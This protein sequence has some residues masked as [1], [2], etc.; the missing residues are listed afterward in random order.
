MKFFARLRQNRSDGPV[1]QKSDIPASTGRAAR[2]KYAPVGPEH[3]VT[4][5]RRYDRLAAEGYQQNVIAYRAINLVARGVSSIP[6]RVKKGQDTLAEHPL[7]SLLQAP[8]PQQKGPGF[9]YNLVGFHLIAGNAFILSVGRDGAPPQELWLLRP[10]TVSVL[11]GRDC[12]P[13]GYIQQSMGAKRRFTAESILHWKAFNPLNDWYGMAPLEAAA[14]A[15]DAHNEGSRWNLAL[16]QNGGTPSG[17]LYQEDSDAHLTDSQFR[18]LK[19]QVEDHYTGAVNAGRPLLLEG[20]LKWQSMGFSPKD[21]DWQT[22]KDM[23]AREIALAFGVPPQLLGI[24]DSQTYSNFSEARQSV[25]EDTIIPL[26]VDLIAELNGWL[27][28]L[29]GDDVHIVADL[30]D[31]PALE[32][33][34]HKKFDRLTRATF[35]TD[36]EKRIALGYPAKNSD[37]SSLLNTP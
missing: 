16:I 17:V 12:L 23:S 9:L 18:A 26:A 34:R 24:P 6:L 37:A 8:N 19:E 10:D 13:L 20:G 35:L 21:M 36:D 4:T 32:A 15:V 5:P 3:A 14:M 7:I 30:D 31:L 22:G 2:P 11:K 28:P 25:W 33:K 29:Y 1:A 27:V